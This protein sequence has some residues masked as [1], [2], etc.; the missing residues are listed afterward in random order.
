MKRKRQKFNMV[1]NSISDEF[2]DKIPKSL[3]E[4]IEKHFSAQLSKQIRI[5][6]MEVIKREA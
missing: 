6:L 2:R 4:E 3:R 1:W 5:I